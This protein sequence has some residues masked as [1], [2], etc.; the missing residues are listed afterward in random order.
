M[1]GFRLAN[2]LTENGKL[3]SIVERTKIKDCKY[4]EDD[5]NWV[6][7]DPNCIVSMNL[8]GLTTDIFDFLDREFKIFLNEK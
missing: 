4:T 3:L 1:V 8:W 6:D 2:T 5:E 7:L